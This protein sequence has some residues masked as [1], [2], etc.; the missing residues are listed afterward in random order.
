MPSKDIKFIAVDMDG[1]LLDHNSQLPEDFYSVYQQLEQRGITLAA[2]SGRQYYSLME[3]FAPISDRMMFIAEN[4]TMVMHQGKELYRC[5]MDK[6]SITSII[7]QA[8]LI[9]GAHI[10]LCG[11]QSAYIETQ[12]PK[13]LKEFAK[14]YHRCQY[15]EDLLSVEDDFIRWL[16][17]TLTALRRMFG[18]V[19]N[20]NLATV[21][22]WS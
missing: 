9:E 19:L 18:R 20:A 12:D 4:G 8:R 13:A 22:R 3:T 15:V 10:V 2:A 6:T 11:T 16:F 1:T 21:I 5:E 7:N 17:V 14:Y